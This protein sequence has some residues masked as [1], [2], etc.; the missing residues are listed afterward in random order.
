MRYPR[1][2]APTE[3]GSVDKDGRHRLL[4]R[5]DGPDY[6]LITMAGGMQRIHHSNEP[7][8]AFCEASVKD[9]SFHE[10]PRRYGDAW[11]AKQTGSSDEETPAFII[12]AGTR[13]KVARMSDM[14][15][16]WKRHT[17]KRELRFSNY[18]AYNYAR[19]KFVY[20][21]GATQWLLM[22]DRSFVRRQST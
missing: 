6:A 1:Y 19:Y 15:G 12:P 3:R 5:L 16:V 13:L 7:A 2:F 18:S 11:Y 21:D 8:E 20:V 14:D 10:V 9:G 4:V 17:T 22:V